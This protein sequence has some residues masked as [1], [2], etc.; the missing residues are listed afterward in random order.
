[1]SSATEPPR[2]SSRGKGAL[3]GLVVG[4][5]AL[6]G[7]GIGLGLYFGNGPAMRSDPP[8]RPAGGVVKTVPQ[9]LEDLPKDLYPKPAAA[10]EA[11]RALANEWLKENAALK[12]VAATFIIGDVL[13]VD[14]GDGT[15][16]VNLS[17][18]VD[19]E[20]STHAPLSGGAWGGEFALGDVR[21]Y[22]EYWSED[23]LWTGLSEADVERLRGLVGQKTTLEGITNDVEF[24]EG[25]DESS[26][27]V[28]KLLV[29][30]KE[31]TAPIDGLKSKQKDADPPLIAG[32]VDHPE[33]MKEEELNPDPPIEGEPAVKRP[34][35]VKNIG[36][37]G[38][39]HRIDADS[40]YDI[41]W[42]PDG[43]RVLAF[44][45]DGEATLWD[46][47]KQT[48][49]DAS[50]T[51]IGGSLTGGHGESHR[52]VAFS[53]D[54]NTIVVGTSW[55]LAVM[56]AGTGKIR[57]EE[58]EEFKSGPLYV[59]S[60]LKYAAALRSVTAAPGELG[61][62]VAVHEVATGK[63]VFRV[64]PT[65]SPIVALSPA[66]L[67]ALADGE[68][69]RVFDVSSGRE[70]KAIAV[71][72]YAHD[73]RFVGDGRTLH[74]EDGRKPKRWN[75]ANPD[76]P[77]MVNIAL[78]PAE[79]LL[80]SQNGVLS[81]D[82]RLAALWRNGGDTVEIVEVSTGAQRGVV[83]A[84]SN[85]QAMQIDC[86]ALTND[87]RAALG[88]VEGPILI[89]RIAATAKTIEALATMRFTPPTDL[90]KYDPQRLKTPATHVGFSS[91]GKRL[92]TGGSV[93]TVWDLSS[94][95]QQIVL[96]V[97]NDKEEI[98]NL[99]KDYKKGYVNDTGDGGAFF[100]PGGVGLGST[101]MMG[102]ASPMPA[103]VSGWFLRPNEETITTAAQGQILHFDLNGPRHRGD[104]NDPPCA[105]MKSSPDGR[106][107]A[108]W[109]VHKKQ[110]NDPR[111]AELVVFDTTT[112]KPQKSLG[113]FPT[114]AQLSQV[115]WVGMI[116]NL[117]FSSDGSLIAAEPP[118]PPSSSTANEIKLWKWQTG[119]EIPI[120]A[121]PPAVELV[122]V[123]DGRQLL[124]LPRVSGFDAV[125]PI[126]LYDV[127]TGALQTQF[128]L[129]LGF[130]NSPTAWAFAPTGKFFAAGDGKGM[131]LLRDLDS[132]AELAR[133]T[134]HNSAITAIGFSSKGDQLATCS[135]DHEVKIWRV[136]DL[137][138]KK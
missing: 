108:A 66:N 50:P 57:W 94:R 112:G 118:P 138:G 85:G 100:T 19:S 73:I 123:D 8:L 134:A 61:I 58:G 69:V 45:N 136:S 65:S 74:I 2:S 78:D 84:K 124:M 7:I 125:K 47:D 135:K 92:V 117:S 38:I 27:T 14:A 10:G 18:T 4:A 13:T 11:A 76:K 41:A 121:E 77:A 71:P 67:L 103:F 28:L 56:D 23:P 126:Q 101:K 25:A 86:V 87:G 30:F 113:R 130:V 26:P 20:K 17:V 132:S 91:D 109:L 68:K 44:H 72:S 111:T 43:R 37:Q 93:T 34:I 1:M 22:P 96:T 55:Q 119:E 48:G 83:Q 128:D 59:D 33:Q 107:A 82:R 21:Y 53:A 63:E 80:E 39:L 62:I 40:I 3:I 51:N 60:S 102:P 24:Q 106:F 5:V 9:M 31:I 29:T 104:F 49:F 88:T 6:L 36:S 129:A 95:R 64:T 133:T 35:P 115:G 70:L 81:P 46:A 12:P 97:N 105:G 114:N 79:K 90:N 16:N 98:A 42:S 99:P 127:S 137:L 52:H 122:L 131:L 116:S 75:L 120:A 89:K 32:I 110:G 54:G 15:Y